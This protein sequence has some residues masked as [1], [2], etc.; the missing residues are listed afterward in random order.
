[1]KNTIGKRITAQLNQVIIL[2]TLSPLQE[3]SWHDSWYIM[4][5]LT[6]KDWKNKHGFFHNDHDLVEAREMRVDNGKEV[7][8][9]VFEMIVGDNA[10][11]ATAGLIWIY[12]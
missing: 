5:S 1:M 10:T 12:A 7:I 8:F 3:D 9:R 6:T 11:V 2:N 4:P